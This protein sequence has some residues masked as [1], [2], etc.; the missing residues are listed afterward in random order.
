MKLTKLWA[1]AL[2][3]LALASCSKDAEPNQPVE[4]PTTKVVHIDLTAGQ[5]DAGLRATYGVKTDESGALTGLQMSDKD[6]ILRVAVRQGTGV[7]VIQDLKFTKTAGRNHA[8][9]SGPIT[10]P[11]SGTG[12]Y[13]IAAF[14]MKEDGADG[15][16][17]LTEQ[18]N[19]YPVKNIVVPRTIE[20]KLAQ[21]NKITLGVPYLTNWQSITVGANAVNPT[22]LYLKPF[23]TILRMR[24]KNESSTRKEFRQIYFQTTAFTTNG[25]DFR[26]DQERDLKP[27]FRPANSSQFLITLPNG[28]VSVEGQSGSTPSYSPWMYL[29]VAPRT[30]NEAPST[31]AFLSF[32]AS[33][34][35]PNKYKAF[36]TNQY[37]PTGSVPMTLVYNDKHQAV[38][39]DPIEHDGEWGSTT[40]TFRA[41]LD[42]LYPYPLNQSKNGFVEDYSMLASNV[43][44]FQYDEVAEFATPQVISGASYS[45]P[46]RDELAAIFPPAE[47]SKGVFLLG[48]LYNQ[49]VY[50]VIEENIKIGDVTQSYKA[51]YIYKSQGF[52]YGIRFKS[53]SNRYRTAYRYRSYTEGTS[54]GVIIEST[55]IGNEP[56]ELSHIQDDGFWTNPARTVTM[57]KFPT[58]GYYDEPNGATN[59]IRT[60]VIMRSST[61]YD[62]TSTYIGMV[63]QTH[64]RAY[65]PLRTK[66]NFLPVYLFKR[67]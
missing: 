35:D 54:N 7:P 44:R 58:Y 1:S 59:L 40:T 17:F 23:G 46:T 2:G 14:L 29:W 63:N 62:V 32:S 57:R 61:A 25:G 50:D 28:M 31:T 33:Q 12:S 8:T 45:L 52:F 24:I 49:P 67:N 10:I 22:T 5:D 19:G 55:P 47:N 53:T 66:Y 43:G 27:F 15:E 39:E 26:L 37:M 34:A 3:L 36:S 16:V 13:T 48:L 11:I 65:M 60:L 4:Q 38:V 6:V 64:P 21:N 51:D 42:Y 9:Y 20:A 18:D 30:L 41:P 56:I